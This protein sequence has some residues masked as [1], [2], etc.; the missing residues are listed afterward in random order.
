MNSTHRHLFTVAALALAVLTGTA[1]Q[2]QS[3]SYSTFGTVGAAVS[4]QDYRYQR[5]IDSDGTLMRDTVV[6]GQ[7]DLQFSTELSATVQAKLAPSARNDQDWDV[8]ASWAFAS[9]RPNNEWLV[10]AGKLRVPLYLYSENLDVGQSYDFARLPTE[11]YSIAPINDV[12]GVYVTRNWALGDSDLSLDVYSGEATVRMRTYTRAQGKSFSNYQTKATG[13]ALTWRADDTT[14]RV[15]LHHASTRAKGSSPVNTAGL[16]PLATGYGSIY[17][18]YGEVPKI[19][20]D[21]ITFGVDHKL[22]GNWRVMFEAVRDIQ[23]DT[24]LGLNTAGGY[25][26]I[27]K[28]MD[29]WTPYVSA[30]VLKTVGS[31]ARDHKL[32]RQTAVPDVAPPITGQINAIQGRI[33]DSV[34]FYDQH[35]LAIGTSYALTPNSKLKAEWLRTWVGEGSSMVDS[36]RGG[37]AVADESIDVFSFSYNFAY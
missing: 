7:L 28:S 17:V 10:R 2:A 8:S 26:A 13:A 37:P 19:R 22:A 33:A 1:A 4:N 34:P 15:G 35:S 27:L 16:Q 12:A 25:I 31:A 29:K 24:T 32:L 5:F 18:P 9:W 3:L 6:G 36:P 21:I 20:N 30:S 11:M 14:V 23:H